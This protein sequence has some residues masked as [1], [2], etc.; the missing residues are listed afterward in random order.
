MPEEEYVENGV[1]NKDF[2]TE[3]KDLSNCA[4][5]SYSPL[6]IYSTIRR[7]NSWSNTDNGIKSACVYVCVAGGRGAEAVACTLSPPAC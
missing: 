5:F 1:V 3:L 4:V 7:V 2:K 6:L